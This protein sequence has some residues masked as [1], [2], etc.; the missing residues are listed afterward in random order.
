[1]SPHLEMAFGLGLAIQHPHQLLIRRHLQLRDLRNQT[2]ETVIAER[3]QMSHD[4]CREDPTHTQ[5]SSM[6]D[7]CSSA[8]TVICRRRTFNT[9]VVSRRL[10]VTN[11][12]LMDPATVLLCCLPPADL[13]YGS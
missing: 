4:Y 7:S 5:E 2:C 3:R 12:T 13:P 1:M 10:E 11:G 6:L 8:V 9:S